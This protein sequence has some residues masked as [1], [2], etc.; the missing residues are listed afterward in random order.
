MLN[1]VEVT[2]PE[3]MWIFRKTTIFVQFLIHLY[4]DQIAE[5]LKKVLSKS[6]L[7]LNDN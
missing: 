7:M 1:G 5:N 3:F 4:I 2:G 6:T